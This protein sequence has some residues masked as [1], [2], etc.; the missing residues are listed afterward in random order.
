MSGLSHKEAFLLP[1]AAFFL[2]AIAY[3]AAI[4]WLKKLNFGQNVRDDTPE[5]HQTKKGT[6]TMGGLVFIPVALVFGLLADSIGMPQLMPYVYL[7]LAFTLGGM[8]IG[9]LDDYLSIRRGKN[10]G[11]RAREK[12]VLQFILVGAFLFGA[13]FL[14]ELTDIWMGGPAIAWS[15]DI[16]GLVFL[17]IFGVWVINAANIADGLDGLAASQGV[18]ALAGMLMIGYM[19]RATTL[20]FMMFSAV[21]MIAVLLA[22]LWFNS[23]P[24]RVFMGDTGSIALGCFVAGYGLLLL[25][26]WMVFLATLIWQLEALSVVI[27]VVYFKLTGGKRIFRMSPVHHHFELC[28]WAETTVTARFI[29]A[30]FVTAILLPLGLMGWLAR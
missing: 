17:V 6:P 8:A 11:L 29:I 13:S 30:S 26:F 24:A 10:L 7:L 27:Q 1:V 28:G 3:P 20:N 18:I 21:V 2:T 5:T 15:G 4:G 22:F 16:P 9:F 23:S 12:F 25:P 19:L 14:N